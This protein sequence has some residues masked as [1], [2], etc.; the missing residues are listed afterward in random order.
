[1]YSLKDLKEAEENLALW[2]RRSENYDGNNPNKY[3]SDLRSGRELVR[4]IRENL[5]RQGILPKTE[6]ELLESE[7]DIAFPDAQSNEIVIYKGNKFKRK[8]WPLEK[9]RSRKSVVSWG[10]GWEPIK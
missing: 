9:S 2:E 6:K 7:L 5:K 8:F 4:L 1:M 10:R 3:Q